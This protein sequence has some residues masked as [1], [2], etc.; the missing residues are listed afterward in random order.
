M[1]NHHS[2]QLASLVH[3]LGF[4]LRILPWEITIKPPFGR[5]CLTFFQASK[6]NPSVNSYHLGNPSVT[7]FVLNAWMNLVISNFIEICADHFSV[8]ILPQ[9]KKAKKKEKCFAPEVTAC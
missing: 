8:K 6:A 4:V 5:I 3:V 1:G 2:H 9:K 7:M